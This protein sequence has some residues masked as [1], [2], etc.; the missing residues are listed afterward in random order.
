MPFHAEDA[1][2]SLFKCF[3]EGFDDKTSEKSS[4]FSLEK[5]Y[6]KTL[7]SLVWKDFSLG[8]TISDGL[9]SSYTPAGRFI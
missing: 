4:S 7:A 5:P 8:F 9:F 1:V 3:D 6:D 2:D